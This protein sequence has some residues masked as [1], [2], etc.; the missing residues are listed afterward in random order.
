MFYN[1]PFYYF[2]VSYSKSQSKAG[3]FTQTL[4]HCDTV[5]MGPRILSACRR[6]AE[7][8]M[9]RAAARIVCLGF[10]IKWGVFYEGFLAGLFSRRPA[11]PHAARAGF[12]FKLHWAVYCKQFKNAFLSPRNAFYTFYC[13]AA[14]AAALRHAGFFVF[15]RCVAQPAAFCKTGATTF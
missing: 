11:K 1:C 14:N 5:A 3:A 2:N 13:R 10:S 8:K 6:A 4:Q 15:C 7:I 12:S 9:Y